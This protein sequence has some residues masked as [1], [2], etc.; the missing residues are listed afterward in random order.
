MNRRK[1]ILLVI[2]LSLYVLFIVPLFF[3]WPGE[4]QAC[5]LLIIMQIL[6]LGRVFPLGYSSILLMLILAFHFWTYEKVLGFVGA[7]VVWLLFATYLLSGALIQSGLAHRLALHILY[8]SKGS[9]RKIVS[10]SFLLI[11][12]L[13]L[14]IPSNIGRANLVTS[15]LDR[16][17]VNVSQA[18][19]KTQL[20]KALFIS[21]CYITAL[22]GA[23][24]ATGASSTIYT[25]G[26][27][28]HQ[29]AD[30]L[31]FLQ[32]MQL[33]VPPVAIFMV[34]LWIVLNLCFPFEK[35]N[36]EFIVSYIRDQLAERG[37]LKK[38]EIKM[39]VIIAGTVLLWILQP[40][41]HYSIPL[42]GLLSAAVTILPGIGVWKWGEAKQ[43]INWDMIL[44]FAS[45]IMLSNVLISSGLL[46]W[47]SHHMITF[48]NSDH[49][50]WLL[51]VFILLIF[52]TRLFFVNVLGIMTFIIPL[53]FSVGEQLSGVSPVLF[54]AV[55]FLAGVPG[56]FFITQSP[57]HMI[58]FS[59][60]YFTE[61]DLMKTGLMAAIIWL[62]ILLITALFYWNGM[63]LG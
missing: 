13:A 5:S 47:I 40:L 4:V 48:I 58:S 3:D 56:F 30:P 59:Y 11:S 15:V 8:W 6:W 51:L 45:T 60:G 7:P 49:L 63:L 22:T 25:Y 43:T 37:Q 20:S 52:V 53:S 26:F 39:M 18:G 41:H 19:G 27:I 42:I 2:A 28:N 38:D 31:T 21:V 35:V 17:M 62:V 24:F 23:F 46:E 16:M 44:F 32:W 57:V 36:P 54:P 10:A 50:V 33:T 9:G 61:K 34:I 55:F 1:S 14:M 12:L 29:L